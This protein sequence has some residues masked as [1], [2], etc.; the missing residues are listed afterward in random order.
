MDSGISSSTTRSLSS[1]LK[2][3][4]QFCFSCYQNLFDSV[5]MFTSIRGFELRNQLWNVLVLWVSAIAIAIQCE[6][7]Y[8]PW[9][10]FGENERETVKMTPCAGEVEEVLNDWSLIEC[11]VLLKFQVSFE[12]EMTF[13]CICCTVWLPRKLRENRKEKKIFFYLDF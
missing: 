13:L 10:H 5:K 11:Q 4:F 9:T 12:L 1:I 3:S 6:S 8:R 2:F 7:R